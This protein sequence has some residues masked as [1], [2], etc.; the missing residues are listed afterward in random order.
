MMLAQELSERDS[1]IRRILCLHIQHHV[2]NA[3]VSFSGEAHFHQCGAVTKQYF[4]YWAEDNTRELHERL[5]H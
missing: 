1:G 2:P 3:S 5:L 4:R